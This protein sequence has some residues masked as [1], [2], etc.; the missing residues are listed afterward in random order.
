MARQRRPVVP[1]HISNYVVESYVRLRK[2]GKDDEAQ[3]KSHSYT[4]ART[5][6][7]VLRLAQA[8]A[9]LRFANE[10]DRGDVDEALRLMEVSKASL[11]EDAD[12]EYE[13]DKSVVSQIFRL[14]K[15]MVGGR[16]S[17]RSKLFGKG[18]GRERDM[19]VD[20]DDEELVLIDVR[21][22]VL[23][24][25]YTEAQLNETI[26]QVSCSMLLSRF[27]RKFTLITV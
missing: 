8:L 21:Q 7:G 9:R 4:T 25:G 10:V 23:G 22:R 18:P 13:P 1:T 11:Q 15:S 5:L 24:S 2:S 3:N 19:D 17:R 20:E 26:L 27:I 14:I 6:L 12:K 16:P